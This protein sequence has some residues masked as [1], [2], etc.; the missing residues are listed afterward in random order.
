MVLD[1]SD[2]WPTVWQPVLHAEVC[3]VCVDNVEWQTKLACLYLD[4][5]WNSHLQSAA[6]CRI[7][8]LAA[9]VRS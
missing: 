3:A 9:T 7:S 4:T 2:Y 1:A 6:I 8:G 5:S